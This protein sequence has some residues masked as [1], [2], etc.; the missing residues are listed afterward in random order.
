MTKPLAGEN[1]WKFLQ[2][3]HYYICPNSIWSD[4]SWWFMC[5][6]VVQTREWSRACRAW[7]TRTRTL[8]LELYFYFFIEKKSQE[9]SMHEV[10]LLGSHLETEPVENVENMLDCREFLNLKHTIY[11]HGVMVKLCNV[12]I[13]WWWNGA[14]NTH[15]FT[16]WN[17]AQIITLP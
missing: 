7:T 4:V 12:E 3:L 15:K 14:D 17:C 5:N 6:T 8:Y 1:R 9:Y 11:S 16:L 13:V 10:F 2:M